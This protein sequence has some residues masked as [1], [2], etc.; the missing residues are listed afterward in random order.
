MTDSR[1]EA[2]KKGAA[3]DD[4]DTLY[5]RYFPQV[6]RFIFR[7]VGIREEVEQ[8]TQ[9]S[10]RKL[11]R[12]F[13]SNP[14]VE[15]PAAML[16]RI[17]SNTCF[18]YLR[19][20]RYDRNLPADVPHQPQQPIS[21]ETELIEKQ[22]KNLVREALKRLSARD[23]ACLLLYQEGLSYAEIATAVHI[24]KSSVGKVLSRATEKLTKAI[25]KGEMP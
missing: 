6:Y 15:N 10:F 8:L 22:N 7:V 24:K 2:Q 14:G 19:R 16:F 23:Q 18:D 17:A 11:Y 9:D 25:R 21:P 13:T 5:R 1:E 3:G 4:F 12:P 20:K